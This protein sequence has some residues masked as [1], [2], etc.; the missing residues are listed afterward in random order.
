MEKFNELIKSEQPV[1]IDFFAEWCGPCKTMM[2]I[3]DKVKESIGEKARIVKIDI[4][5]FG[6][7]A[8]EYRIQTVPTFIIFKDGEPLW[9]HSGL[10]AQKELISMLEKYI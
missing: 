10:I 8:T 4:D 2:P 9:R 7:L 5:K 1:L 6:E 3:L